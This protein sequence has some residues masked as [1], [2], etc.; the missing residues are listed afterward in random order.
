MTLRTMHDLAEDLHGA[1]SSSGCKFE[2]IDLAGNE[3]KT[4]FGSS[5]TLALKSLWVVQFPLRV[6]RRCLHSVIEIEVEANS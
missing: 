2:L 1:V 6:E 3:S 5:K 4:H